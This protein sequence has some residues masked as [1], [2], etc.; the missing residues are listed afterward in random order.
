[1]YQANFVAVSG[2]IVTLSAV[3]DNNNQPGGQTLNYLTHMY[4]LRQSTSVYASLPQST[5]LLVYY[6]IYVA[7][8]LFVQFSRPKTR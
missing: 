1:M 4:S 2:G 6:N 8:A 3:R 5:S 7:T